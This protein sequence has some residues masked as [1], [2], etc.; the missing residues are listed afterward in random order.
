MTSQTTITPSEPKPRLFSASRILLSLLIVSILAIAVCEIAG[1]PFLRTPLEKLLST[2]LD[3]TVRLDAPFKLR[4]IGG[5]KL[6]VGG[7]YIAVPAGFDSAYLVDAKNV[8]LA[9]RYIDLIQFKSTHPIRIKSLRVFNVDAQLERHAD[10]H[11][12]W[13]FKK[14]D[15]PS[16]PIPIIETLIVKNGVAKFDDTITRSELNMS[17]NT[18]EGASDSRPT[19]HV[20]VKGRSE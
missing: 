15:S 7:L 10:G 18:D 2:H 13:Q 12:S 1:W 16:S 4:L 5:I 9:L 3:R 11:A 6:Q 14:D 8:E 19:S 20:L 17:F